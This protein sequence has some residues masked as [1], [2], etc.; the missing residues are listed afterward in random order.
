MDGPLDLHARR[1]P[2]MGPMT[3]E[4]IAA[5]LKLPALDVKGFDEMVS[6]GYR[7]ARA[8]QADYV[9]IRHYEMSEQAI[10]EAYKRTGKRLRNPH[11]GTISRE[12]DD[13]S[14]A[15]RPG[16]LSLGRSERAPVP[17]ETRR[18]TFYREYEELRREHPDLPDPRGFQDRIVE[19]IKKLRAEFRAASRVTGTA[20]DIGGFVGSAGAELTHP[21]NLALLPLGAP[22]ALYAPV[23]AGLIAGVGRVLAVGAV[24]S[25]VAV[26]AQA[27][28]EAEKA[29]RLRELGIEYADEEMWGNIAGAAVAGF[30]LGV[31]LRTLV[32]A[33]RAGRA[34]LGR[35][36]RLEGDEAATVAE[37]MELDRASNP[38]PGRGDRHQ[39]NLFEARAA[40]AEGR[41]ARIAPEEAPPGPT[42]GR[43]SDLG[44]GVEQPPP[45]PRQGA[46]EGSQAVFT[47]AGRRVEVRYEVV[48]ARSLI[49]SHTGYF[50]PNPAYPGLLQ[51]RDRGRAAS[52]AQVQEIAARLEPERLGRSA[53]ASTGAPIV[54]PDNVVESGNGRVL[55]VLRAYMDHPERVAALRESLTRQGFDLTGIDRPVLVA[56]RLT[57]LTE[58]E[59]IAFAREA[60][61]AVAMR[62]GAAET[63]AADAARIAPVL[64]LWRG[65]DIA[66]AGNADLVRGFLKALPAT[67]RA[68]AWTQKGGLSQE[69][70]RRI[71]AAILHAAYEDTALVAKLMESP[72]NDIRAIGG[73]LMDVAPAWAQMRAAARRND[74]APDMDRTA[75]LL[76][77]LRTV[78]RARA[79]GAK[80]ADLA[81]Q[82]SLFDVP[83]AGRLFLVLMHKEPDLARTAS[84]K[85]IAERLAGY[86][87]EANKTQPG[88]NLFG[89]PPARAEDLL[90]TRAQAALAREID[91]A[92]AAREAAPARGVDEIGE[93]AR[94][95]QARDVLKAKDVQV[96]M[97]DTVVSAREAMEAADAAVKEAN[98]IRAC[99]MGVAL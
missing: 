38:L 81:A 30:G 24:E 14:F 18:E 77:A 89:E 20:G 61:E 25:G 46:P 98:V 85:A 41:E 73:A 91:E 65:G 39:A 50:Q 78:E 31:G 42:G 99:A 67:E 64:D 83:E 48:D 11:V 37:R 68:A 62:M 13:E 74:I 19:E 80:V 33:Y 75:D 32:G 87:D 71:Q 15:Q 23:R 12:R 6:L 76:A 86:V 84:R 51:P 97:G 9:A 28:I 27:L 2:E 56:R 5:A 59:R 79:D 35:A 66:S 43:R 4:Q 94:V 49:A 22:A 54:G 60:N 58:A 52:Q 16:Y 95:T 45:A 17:Y 44:P 21:V 3:A 92:K 47:A 1:E 29:P 57:P 34:R 90:A 70:V 7:E 53:D 82:G 93:D 55:A 63:A 26:G 10:D 72:S 8:T 36:D 96:E 88:A 69:G 40:L